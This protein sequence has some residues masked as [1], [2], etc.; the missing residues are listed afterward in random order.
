MKISYIRVSTIE[1]N[2]QRQ[3]EALKKYGI[4]SLFFDASNECVESAYKKMLDENKDLEIAAQPVLDIKTIDEKFI[5]YIFTL[6]LKPEVKLGEYKKL[7]VK[8][9]E[10]SVTKKEISEAIRKANEEKK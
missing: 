3:I 2:E 5:E 1:Q 10:V 6:T 7:D 9:D 8:K 4:E